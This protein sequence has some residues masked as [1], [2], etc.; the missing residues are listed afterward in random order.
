MVGD[1]EQ[2][3]WV[4]DVGLASTIAG[5]LA[6]HHENEDDNDGDGQEEEDEDE[7]NFNSLGA[8]SRKATDEGFL[9]GQLLSSRV[10][11]FL[12]PSKSVSI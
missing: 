11:Q 8:M 3:D 9:R 4:G 10:S 1:D 6:A 5:V 2:S 12:C 7:T